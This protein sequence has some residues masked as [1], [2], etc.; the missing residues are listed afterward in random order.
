MN[1]KEDK[2]IA[3]R[4]EQS[5]KLITEIKL[6]VDMFYKTDV[7]IKKSEIVKHIKVS[8]STLDK[9]KE[10][11]SYI[12]EMQEKQKNKKPEGIDKAYNETAM[13]RKLMASYVFTYQLLQE[14]NMFLEDAISKME[15]EIK[16]RKD[17]K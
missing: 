10:I 12:K 6:L 7:P 17:Q 15:Q 11:S 3:L 9:N 4:M 8:R 13:Y 14:Q 5:Q 1:N 2:M 16:D